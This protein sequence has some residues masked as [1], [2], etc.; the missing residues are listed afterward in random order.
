MCRPLGYDNILLCIL[1]SFPKTPE[2]PLSRGRRIPR[3]HFHQYSLSIKL[4]NVFLLTFYINIFVTSFTNQRSS[5][6]FF[7]RRVVD[8]SQWDRKQWIGF[9]QQSQCFF[10][11]CFF[12]GDINWI[13]FSSLYLLIKAFANNRI[14]IETQRSI[15]LLF[16]FSFISFIPLSNNIP[17]GIILCTYILLFGNRT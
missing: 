6:S 5:K 4:R 3:I 11:F 2:T 7:C 16:L 14:R 15:W 12:L 13:H 10:F 9:F 17:T 1:Q 8:F